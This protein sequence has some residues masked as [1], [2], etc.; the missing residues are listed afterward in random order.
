MSLSTFDLALPRIEST[1]FSYDGVA[2]QAIHCAVQIVTWDFCSVAA[3]FSMHKELH[4][5][6]N[7]YIEIFHSCGNTYESHR[8][9]CFAMY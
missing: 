1:R 7:I 8:L 6:G 3:P 5:I 9:Y 4:N 2:S